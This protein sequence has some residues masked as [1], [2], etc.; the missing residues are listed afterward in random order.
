MSV[1]VVFLFVNFGPQGTH[2]KLQLSGIVWSFCLSDSG[3]VGH[4]GSSC[5]VLFGLFVCQVLA[6]G[7]TLA[8]AVG[9]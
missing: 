5:L 2:S 8:P 3:L 1:F 7:D 4:S 6:S 9:Y